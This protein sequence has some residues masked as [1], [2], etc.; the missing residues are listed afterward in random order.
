MS[1][2]FRILPVVKLAFLDDYLSLFVSRTPEAVP[3]DAIG[4][5]KFPD[6]PVLATRRP[7]RLYGRPQP[8]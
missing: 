5:R 7:A 3:D 4:L 6:N 1:A 8:N 2:D